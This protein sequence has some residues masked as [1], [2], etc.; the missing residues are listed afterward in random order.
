MCE[1]VSDEVTGLVVTVTDPDAV[2]AAVE[3][4]AVDAALRE[5]LGARGRDWVWQ[6]FMIDLNI[7]PIADA[8]R[9]TSTPDPRV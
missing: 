9:A 2:A 5:R 7:R 3:R 8:M 1:A 6:H 4:L